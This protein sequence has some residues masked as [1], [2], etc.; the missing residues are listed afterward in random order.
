M[1]VCNNRG[2]GPCVLIGLFLLSP[3]SALLALLGASVISWAAMRL[4]KDAEVLKTGLFSVNGALLGAVWIAFPQ[5]PLWAQITATVLGAVVMAKVFVPMAERM[6]QKRSAYVLFSLPYVAAAWVAILTLMAAGV[7]DAEL[8]RG[9]RALLANDL[10]K[11]ERHFL[12]TE[13]HT[14]EAEASRCAGLGWSLF[15]RGDQTVP[16][17]LSHACSRSKLAWPMPTTDSA[18][19]VFAK[20]ASRMPR[21]LFDVRWHSTAFLPIRGMDWAGALWRLTSPRKPVRTE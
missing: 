5:M 15:R 16:N 2:T 3:Q 11:A 18:G 10:D 12:H 1:F 6:H 14:D 9:W 20:T 17:R 13:V 4:A 19:A 21:W 7:H 8:T